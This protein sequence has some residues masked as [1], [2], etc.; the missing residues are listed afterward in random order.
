MA[1]TTCVYTECEVFLL[2]D[3]VGTATT[4]F[5]RRICKDADGNTQPPEDTDLNG[6]AYPVRG[7]VGTCQNG[8]DLEMKVMCDGGTTSFLR[9]YV[10]RDGQLTGQPFDTDL[11]GV[12]YTADPAGVSVGPCPQD[13]ECA[14]TPTTQLL[15]DIRADGTVEPFLRHM[16]VDCEGNV[17]E[18]N[19]TTLGGQD[20]TVDPGG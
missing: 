18:T 14:P 8:T 10:T 6:A 5:I 11:N 17:L 19:D 16:V 15:Y 3:K 7:D 9:W 1:R 20:Y 12:A 2:C 13:P 4:L